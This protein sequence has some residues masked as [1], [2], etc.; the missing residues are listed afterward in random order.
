[1]RRHHVITCMGLCLVLFACHEAPQ[2][3]KIKGK[4]QLDLTA[5]GKPFSL[6]VPDTTKTRFTINE[7]VSGALEVRVGDFFG[8]VINEQACDLEL[9]RNDVVGDEVN[10]LKTFKESEK[11]ELVWESE[12][13]GRQE[14]H[15]MINKT[16]GTATY[17]FEDLRTEEGLAFTPEQTQKM[18]TCC[19]E[20]AVP[21]T[22]LPWYM[23]TWRGQLC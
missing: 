18:Y 1:M 15:F 21:S 6:M 17:C 11:N 8:I 13:A 22:K 19:H 2:Q 7:Q 9:K 4:V 16:V 23:C 10:K 5:Y 3:P 20:V 14:L 12:L